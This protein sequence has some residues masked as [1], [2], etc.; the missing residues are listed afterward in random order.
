MCCHCYSTSVAAL[1]DRDGPYP[2]VLF[3]LCKQMPADQHQHHEDKADRA[4]AQ[5]Q[6][7]EPE[8]TETGT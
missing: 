2:V 4:A 1:P 5:G 6:C 3:Q 7:K 8:Y